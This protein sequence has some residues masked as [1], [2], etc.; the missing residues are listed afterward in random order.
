MQDQPPTR[1]LCFLHKAEV[2]YTDSVVSQARQWINDKICSL[3]LWEDKGGD[4]CEPDEA[5]IIPMID[6][7]TEGFKGHVRII[8]PTKTASF[9]STLWMFPPQVPFNPRVACSSFLFTF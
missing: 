2:R 7:G 1:V 9:A 3:I 5:Y 4:V 6:G 8:H